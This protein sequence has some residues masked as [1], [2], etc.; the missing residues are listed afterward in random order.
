MVTHIPGIRRRSLTVLREL[1]ARDEAGDKTTKLRPVLTISRMTGAGGVAIAAQLAAQLRAGEE[2]EELPWA[3]FDKTL[4]DAVLMD[5]ELP[6]RLRRYMPEDRVSPVNALLGEIFGLHPSTLALF[7]KTNETMLRLA[8]LGHVILVGRGANLV[9]AQLPHA[10]HVRLVCSLEQG[11]RRTMTNRACS[12][13]EAEDLV[14]REDRAR[15][16]YVKQHF[17]VDITDPRHYHLILNTD[18]FTD[19]E[20]VDLLANTVTTHFLRPDEPAST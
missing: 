8:H 19:D 10:L 3:A 12:E 9:T 4:I 2:G 17:G 11:V 5:Q 15:A 14:L 13:R 16:R 18:R 20:V 1:I 6:M 7:Q